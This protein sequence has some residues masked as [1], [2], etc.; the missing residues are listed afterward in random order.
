MT[1]PALY[2]PPAL[3]IMSFLKKVAFKDFDD[4]KNQTPFEVWPASGKPCDTIYREVH[5]EKIGY[6]Y[7]GLV[8][9]KEECT[10]NMRF[11]VLSSDYRSKLFL[12]VA[13]TL[14]IFSSISCVVYLF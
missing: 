1:L 8:H 10:V 11:H 4:N 13:S 12:Q 9:L 3:K 2:A 7:S 6:T 14:Q 5:I